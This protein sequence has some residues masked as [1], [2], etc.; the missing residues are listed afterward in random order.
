MEKSKSQEVRVRIA[1]SPTGLFHIGTA[2]L[3]WN[4]GARKK[5]FLDGLIE[6]GQ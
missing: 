3:N 4:P 6:M 1:P 5:F 2:F